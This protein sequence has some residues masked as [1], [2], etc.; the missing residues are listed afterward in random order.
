MKHLFKSK[1]KNINWKKPLKKLCEHCGKE[2]YL[3]PFY[4]KIRRFCSK[5]CAGFGANG[6]KGKHHKEGIKR[7]IGKS[8]KGRKFTEEQLLRKSLVQR[9]NKGSNWKG[10]LSYQTYP[11]EFNLWLKKQIRKQTNFTCN[12][13]KKRGWIVHHI[14]FN[15]F[16]NKIGNLTTLCNHCHGMI[17]RNR[18]IIGEDFENTRM[19]A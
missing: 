17:T 8:A 10:G 13:C 12:L 11:L 16:N 1:E 19:E 15:K 4:A 18:I 2:M 5:S 3:K 9:G 7:I 14:D 6:F